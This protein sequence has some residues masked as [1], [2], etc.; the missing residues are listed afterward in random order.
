VALDRGSGGL[1]DR[2]PDS[3]LGERAE[4]YEFHIQGQLDPRR[5]RGLDGVEVAHELSGDTVL[6]VRIVDQSALYGFVS[7][8]R[9]LGITLLA[10]RRL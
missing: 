4:V 10:M 8:L 2:A 5:L 7:R 1:G 6:T 9:D 3:P